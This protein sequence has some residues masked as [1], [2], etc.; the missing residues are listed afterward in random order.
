MNKYI[1]LLG[2]IGILI[3][4]GTAGSILTQDYNITIEDKETNFDTILTSE[5]RTGI[6][7][8][9]KCE[10]DKCIITLD[11]NQLF[12]GK[13][14]EVDITPKCIGWNQPAC[15]EYWEN[16]CYETVCNKYE[17]IKEEGTETC[18][19]FTCTDQKYN[20]CLIYESPT[21][22]TWETV[23][24]QALIE[25]AITD[26]LNEYVKITNERNA[27]NTTPDKTGVINVN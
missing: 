4:V 1:I 3:G 25:Q 27:R 24:K 20:E 7:Y 2:I 17:T 13:E 23:N 16:G 19:E 10:T 21:C 6:N 11:K 26:T 12:N 18:I 8:T 22:K 14:I 9:E 5:L 15:K